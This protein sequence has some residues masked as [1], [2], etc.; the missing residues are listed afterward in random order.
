MKPK[1][2]DLI[3]FFENAKSIPSE[4]ELMKGSV[5]TD[6]S[7]FISSHIAVLQANKGNKVF[8]PY[9]ARLL[10]LYNILNQ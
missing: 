10:L 2:E 8:L 9:Y 7:L 1:P 4:I 6:T 5:I 3:L